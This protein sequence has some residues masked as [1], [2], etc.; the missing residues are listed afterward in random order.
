M[1]SSVTRSTIE[2]R[3]LI[4]TSSTVRIGWQMRKGHRGGRMAEET[5]AAPLQTRARGLA[6][7]EVIADAAAPLS[8]AELGERLGLHRSI[9]YRIVRTLENHGF[10]ARDSAGRLVL[11]ASL[12]AV[13]RAVARDL[14]S[15][16]L[17]E[18]TLVA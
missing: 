9:T 8:I 14:Q 12:A 17:P 1:T 16:A 4:P 11:G 6:A 18:L 10:V 3:A 13:A 7:L 5:T 2:R 15:A